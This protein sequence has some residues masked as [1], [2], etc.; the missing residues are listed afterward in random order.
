MSLMNASDASTG[1]QAYTA[2]PILYAKSVTR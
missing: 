2:K 1:L